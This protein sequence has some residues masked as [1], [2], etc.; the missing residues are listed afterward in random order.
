MKKLKYSISV[1]ML[2]L[3]A[4]FALV[5]CGDEPKGGDD[6]SIG[7]TVLVYMVANNS[8][9][10]VGYDLMDIE[11]M[12]KASL[13]GDIKDGRL[14]VYHSDVN[15][16]VTL[17][18]VKDGELVVLKA[19]DNSSLSV[20]SSRMREVVADTKR[21][22]PAADY[23]LVLWSHGSGWLVD[24]IED[25]E[26][27]APSVQ[28]FCEDSRK[29]MNVSTIA[30]TLKGEDFGFI[31]FD[32]C[33]MG[34][35]E[36][37]YELQGCADYIVASPTELPVYGMPYDKNI[38]HFFKPVPDL[39]KA[40]EETFNYYNTPGV[41]P[42]EWCTMAVYD[43]KAVSRLADATKA[44]YS[45]S[46]IGFPDGYQPQRYSDEAVCYYY[47]FVDYVNILTDDK[48]L[49]DEFNAAASAVV[50]YHAE[51]PMLFNVVKLEHCNGFATY[52]MRNHDDNRKNYKSTAWYRDVVSLLK[53]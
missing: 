48:A 36:V 46:V 3:L 1:T 38:K 40:A 43:M 17:N 45:A 22:A 53:S 31:Y 13:A 10:R 2:S 8:L 14:I 16:D 9:G 15:G 27:S 41:S 39:V 11:E 52:I 30:R 25:L 5:S 44:V 24:G 33:L 21:F 34:S 32:C 23:G 7:R 47:D 51:T 4:L 26:S 6:D 42:V 29:R 35:I 49:L 20:E 37:I 28:S 12:K 19:Y 18:E 50:I